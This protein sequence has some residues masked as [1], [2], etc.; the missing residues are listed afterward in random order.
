MVEWQDRVFEIIDDCPGHRFYLLSKQPQNLI[1]FSPFPENCWVGVTA[2]GYGAF[3]KALDGLKVI[4]AKVKSG[5][6]C[7]D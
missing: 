4:E 5:I 2:T 1:K 7:G 6:R 3:N